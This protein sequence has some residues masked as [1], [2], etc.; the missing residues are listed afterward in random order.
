MTK[1][2]KVKNAKQKAK[3]TLKEVAGKASGDDKLKL[4]GKSDQRKASLKQAGKKVKD[5]LK[6]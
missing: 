6:K 1:T 5:A 4:E 2:D 3:G